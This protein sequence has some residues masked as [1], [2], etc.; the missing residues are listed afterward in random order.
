[1]SLKSF[2]EAFVEKYPSW[3]G[4][5]TVDGPNAT[6]WVKK[7]GQILGEQPV[8]LRIFIVTTKLEEPTKR[9]A[10]RWIEVTENQTWDGFVVDFANEHTK[11]RT[12]LRTM[13]EITTIVQ[14]RE[15]TN[16]NYIQRLKLTMALLPEKEGKPDVTAEEEE[17]IADRFCEG[18]IPKHP[19][20]VKGIPPPPTVEE[21]IKL[22]EK[23]GKINYYA[24]VKD[25]ERDLAE[26]NTIAE[27]GRTNHDIVVGTQ[28]IPREQYDTF[29]RDFGADVVDSVS[30]DDLTRMFSM[31]SIASA[32]GNSSEARIAKTI[33]RMDAGFARRVLLGSRHFALVPAQAN[34]PSGGRFYGPNERVASNAENSQREVNGP[35][36]GERQGC[37]RCG[38]IGHFARVCPGRRCYGC[39]EYG[40][41]QPNCPNRGGGTVPV[42]A[43]V[44]ARAATP[45][46]GVT[47]AAGARRV[48]IVESDEC[49]IVNALV[50]TRAHARTTPVQTPSQKSRAERSN[51][52]TGVGSQRRPVTI[53]TQPLSRAMD[54]DQERSYANPPPDGAGTRLMT[55]QQQRPATI[56]LGEAARMT[57]KKARVIVIPDPALVESI[58]NMPIPYE[59][60]VKHSGKLVPQL[61]AAVGA[62]WLKNR[63]PKKPKA[64]AS[65]RRAAKVTKDQVTI[66]INDKKF[67]NAIID[68]GN[69]F[70]I[71]SDHVAKALGMSVKPTGRFVR[72]ADGRVTPLVGTVDDVEFEVAGH[73]YRQA[74]NVVDCQ[75]TYDVLL[76]DNW[77]VAA[78][79]KAD[80]G[81]K[82]GTY[83]LLG[84]DGH[85]IPLGV[86]P[87]EVDEEVSEDDDNIHAVYED[88]EESLE[89]TAFRVTVEP[90]DVE[91]VVEGLQEVKNVIIETSANKVRDIS[92]Y[93]IDGHNVD[94]NPDLNPEQIEQVVELLERNKDRFTMELSGLETTDVLEHEIN[95]RPGAKPVYVGGSRRY[96]PKEM[97]FLKKNIDDELKAGK[98]VP[99]DSEWCAP[100]SLAPKKDGSIRKC[101]AYVGLNKVTERESWPLPNIEE[102]LDDL[103]GY[104]Y[105]SGFDGFQG[106]YV[107]GIRKEDVKYLGF[108]TPWGTYSYKVLPFGIKNAPHTFSRFI[109]K[110]YK[111]LIGRVLNA[112]MDDV[113]A[114]TMDWNEHLKAL[115]SIFEAARKAGVKYKTSKVHIGYPK[116]TFIGHVVGTAGLDVMADKIEKV[117]NF[118]PLRSKEDI[119][120]FLGLTGYYRRFVWN[121]AKV[122]EP[123]TR[124]LRKTIAFVWEKEQ[125][126]SMLELQKRLTEAPVLKPPD[127]LKDWLLCVDACIYAMG[128]A[129]EQ[130]DE[131]GRIR[132]VYYYSKTFQGAERNYSTFEQECLAIVFSV[133]KFR[134][135]I[136]GRHVNIFSDHAP[137]AW[138]FSK[139]DLTGR[140]ARWQMILAEYDFTIKTR[141]GAKNGNA[142]GMSRVRV[143]EGL[144]SDDIDDELPE[145]I[146]RLVRLVEEKWMTSSWYRDIYTYLTSG[147]LQLEDKVRARR[148]KRQAYRYRIDETGGLLFRDADNIEKKCA[149]EDTIEGIL[150]RAHNIGGHYGAEATLAHI[151][152]EVWWPTMRRDVF[153]WARSC[154]WCQRYGS[155]PRNNELHPTLVEFPFEVIFIDLIEDLPT[156]DRG[157]K[158]VVVVVDAFTK[159]VEAW[160]VPD[161]TAASVTRVLYQQILC[162]FGL[163]V[164]IRTDGGP[165]FR[166]EFKE[167]CEF[168]EINHWT[169]S[170]RHPQSQ[171]QV[172]AMNKQLEER[173]RR[174]VPQGSSQW[175][176]YL[177]K[178]V[179]D[180]NGHIVASI[181]VTPR[182][183]LMGYVGQSAMKRHVDNRW[184]PVDKSGE[185]PT[186]EQEVIARFVC[187]REGIRE[188]A[189]QNRMQSNDKMK[190]YYD[191]KV[192]SR[193]FTVGD[194]VYVFNLK[195]VSGFGHKLEPRWLGPYP[196][197]WAGKKGSYGVRTNR[198]HYGTSDGVEKLNGD[199]LKKEVVRRNEWKKEMRPIG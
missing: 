189:Y 155:R 198:R 39:N 107:I 50:T 129:L 111:D 89:H 49:E 109:A 19:V 4:T 83:Y 172:E 131:E 65:V 103:A 9:W 48:T 6:K 12:R 8:E 10:A 32:S 117:M 62:A 197:V 191:S 95:V 154:E 135:Y 88:E 35:N 133:K 25:R 37:L 174:N 30:M 176:L 151:R 104:N 67:D 63:P 118:E 184:N 146:C 94:I 180:I 13:S 125:E 61:K 126:E 187:Q 173:L 186:E 114:R 112:Y 22:V 84:Q 53:G 54:T 40:H 52:P 190:R 99:M 128:S 101:V 139:T 183:A 159:W 16:A 181:G 23:H 170:T 102:I 56:T 168:F 85:K 7:L 96:A 132:P 157:M 47:Q 115:D 81:N 188:M 14:G 140:P 55:E 82:E 36:N 147:S 58:E 105:Y 45:E 38:E 2:V 150:S 3:P 51:V 91:E 72:M 57:T 177:P 69:D 137:L 106:Y 156:T 33:D 108:R 152:K 46:S 18:L 27:A 73:L 66:W 163:P 79:A 17:Y 158:A 31:W 11:K 93:S 92:A 149:M 121:Y 124:I 59:T 77:L 130:E 171:G 123:L 5:G 196:V 100:L 167:L 161:K 195:F 70:T 98:I 164:A 185:P 144:D 90:E 143:R 127:W 75:R 78:R 138:L 76:G 60:L 166:T 192:R 142:D 145:P 1:M 179:S 68:P 80:W 120:A 34:N 28:K 194:S 26:K 141:P 193:T 87:E 199:M 21:A 74:M 175:D 182:E 119:R 122:A 113:C 97:E 29:Q 43:E 42:Q 162:R 169:G 44:A 148:V 110:V 86:E 160:A 116:M 71:L 153:D 41:I 24:D 15:E 136:L 178:A 165:A 20:K 64:S 134:P